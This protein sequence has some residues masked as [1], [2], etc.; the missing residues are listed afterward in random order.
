MMFGQFFFRNIYV[1]Y[2]GYGNIFYFIDK[3]STLDPEIIKIL[4]QQYTFNLSKFHHSFTNITE[5][6]QYIFGEEKLH[7]QQILDN[8][9][10][11]DILLKHQE[12]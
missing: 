7:L 3:S 9:Y 11:N 10:S 1:Q 4:Q 2:T 6:E 5:V 8:G 12:I